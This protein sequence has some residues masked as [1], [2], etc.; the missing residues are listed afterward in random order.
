M[1]TRLLLS[2]STLLFLALGCS[3]ETTTPSEPSTA[4]PQASVAEAALVF[5]QI[6]AGGFPTCGVTT[7]GRAYC[8]GGNA[9]IGDGEPDT[10]FRLTPSAVAGALSFRQVSAGDFYSCGVT[11]DYRAY[12]WG[13]NSYGQ[14]GDGTT[15]ERLAP[16]KVAGGLRFRQVQVSS[17]AATEFT[18]GVSYPDNRAYCWGYNQDGGVGDGTRV[19]RLTP[20]PVRG[21]HLFRQLSVGGA[22]ACGVTTANVA[23]CWG[24]NRYGQLGDSTSVPRR[25]QPSRVV[26]LRQWRQLDAGEVHTCAVTSADKAF[27]WGSGHLGAIGNGKSYLSFWPRAVSGGLAFRR[28]TAGVAHTCGE[29]TTNRTYCWGFNFSGELGDGTTTT[30]LTPVMVVGGLFFNQVSAGDSHTCGKTAAGAAYCWGDNSVGRLGDGT[31]TNRLTPTPVAGA[32]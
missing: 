17:G 19:N 24:D 5:T 2:T 13:D 15:T 7:N 12:C 14:L 21:G 3:D 4:G 6:S 16:V 8:W 30:R 32:S 31:Q 18:C 25:L 27:C 28:V 26:G 1:H 11:T 22:H 23:F 20:V 29:T 10:H 9:G